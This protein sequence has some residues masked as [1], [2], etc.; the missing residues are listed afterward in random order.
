[1][2]YG[3]DHVYGSPLAAA[4]EATDRAVFLR[5]TYLHLAGAVG[6]FMLIEGL[7][8]ALVPEQTLLR[9]TGRMI[10]GY[11]WIVVLLAFMAVSWFAE[12]MARNAQ[13]LSTQYMG[14]GLY[15]LAESVIF[16]PLLVIAQRLGAAD[17]ENLILK[18]AIITGIAFVG[19]TAIIMVTGADFR[20]VR[21]LLFAATWIAVG[22][23]IVGALFG[24]TF[25]LFGIG[26]FIAL[27]CGWIIYT[28][29]EVLHGY[30]TH[31]YVAAALALF[32]SVALLFWYVLQF[33]IASRD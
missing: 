28:T 6:L 11:M 4:A 31:Q 17:G 26:L 15:V 22:V 13:S 21:T 29:S 5:R 12:S 25:G 16:I 33:V 19:L 23:V 10:Q 8:F 1:M 30:Y 18:A 27:A 24:F 32:A 20:W 2:A 7:I 9:L 14:L 3:T